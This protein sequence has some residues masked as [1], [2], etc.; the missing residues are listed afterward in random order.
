MKEKDVRVKP[1]PNCGSR[2]IILN[3]VVSARLPW[4]YFVECDDCHWC[5]KTK[6]FSKRAE[7][8]WNNEMVI[9]TANE[10]F[11]ELGYKLKDYG[12]YGRTYQRGLY[13]IS[14]RVT[15]PLLEGFYKF[16]GSGAPFSKKEIL[17]CARLIEEMEREI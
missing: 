2:N 10:M 5:G 15:G 7:R 6:L 9:K 3:H 16:S 11:E 4:W 1:C 8:S 12:W 14:Y 17:A 13:T